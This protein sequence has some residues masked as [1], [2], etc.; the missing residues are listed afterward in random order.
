MDNFDFRKF[1]K[2]NPLLKEASVNDK[3]ELEDFEA[4]SEEE[5][6]QDVTDIENDHLEDLGFG[7]KDMTKSTET[8]YWWDCVTSIDS[9]KQNFSVASST[10]E[11]ALELAEKYPHWGQ[12]N[13]RS[14]TWNDYWDTYDKAVE[15]LKAG[16]IPGKQWNGE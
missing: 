9:D 15:D 10:K 11:S 2:D 7:V 13:L 4:P 16:R 12:C 6:E 1:I 5:L 8:L 14:G 3:G